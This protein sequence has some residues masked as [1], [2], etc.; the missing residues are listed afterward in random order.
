[1][2][3]SLIFVAAAEARGCDA[4]R[5]TALGAATQP[6][7]AQNKKHDFALPATL[8]KYQHEAYKAVCSELIKTSTKIR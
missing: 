5:R 3:R 8:N 1:M 6:I 7:N 2:R 4:V